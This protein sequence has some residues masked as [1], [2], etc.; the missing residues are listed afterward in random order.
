M[1]MPLKKI[2]IIYYHSIGPVDPNWN[3][4]YLT[5][6]ATHFEDQ[7]R[8]FSKH[9]NIID[10]K[11]HFEIRA[12]KIV[13]PPRPL[14]I[15]IDDGYLDNWMWAYPLLKKYQAPATIFVSPEFMDP[16]PVVRPNLE[17][18]WEGRVDR[19][20][21]GVN[22]YL[23]WEEMRIM[24]A[25]GVI[26]IQSHT[27][28]H[29]KY[30]VSDQLVGFHHPG[31]DALYPITNIYP[32]EKPFCLS[33]PSFEQLLPYGTPFFEERSSVI[34]R[35]VEINPGFTEACV[36]ALQGYDFGNYRFDE[37]FAIV[38]PLYEQ[39]RKAG[40]LIA[41]VESE[42]HYRERLRYEIVTSKGLIERELDKV[43]EFMCWP[44]GDNNETAHELAMEAGYLATTVGKCE[45]V[46]V[47]LDRLPTR[48]AVTP[49]LKSSGLGILKARTKIDSFVGKG[50]ARLAGQAYR[51]LRNR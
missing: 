20:E 22:G 39:Y 29:A 47:T 32:Q 19:E 26:D 15:T 42:D 36:E 30:F 6:E 38:R 5:L 2:P 17:D 51:R 23:S 12:G 50:Y 24:E 9:F 43:V 7:L 18:V 13:G 21:L 35:R 27:M 4:N 37:A 41:A 25:S 8:Y 40:N 44:H 34:A 14:V 10:L 1:V 11:T 33:N 16:N 45:D 3:R 28:T 46:P 48:F 31:A 49:F